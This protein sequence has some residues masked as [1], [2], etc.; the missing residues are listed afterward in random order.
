MPFTFQSVADQPQLPELQEPLLQPPPL[1]I[2]LAEEMLNP[3][4]GPA[5]M[6]STLMEPQVSKSPFSTKNVN[7]LFS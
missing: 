3:D 6:N 4:R 2:G 7:L 1:P 5:S